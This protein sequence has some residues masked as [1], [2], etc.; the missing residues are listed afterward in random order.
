MEVTFP[1]SPH[2][3]V[4]QHGCHPFPD[5]W[6]TDKSYYYYFF[7]LVTGLSGAVATRVRLAERC[8]NK[9]QTLQT[10][11]GR[12]SSTEEERRYFF[13]QREYV[14]RELPE[15]RGCRRSLALTQARALRAELMAMLLLLA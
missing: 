9:P 4:A 1:P 10:I 14:S 11:G 5:V 3:W 12:P 7:P 13:L 8:T 2:L 6:K 15:L